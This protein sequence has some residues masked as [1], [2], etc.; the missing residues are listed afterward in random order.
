MHVSHADPHIAER[1]REL[2]DVG[3]VRANYKG[4]PAIICTAGM[5]GCSCASKGGG[6][7]DFSSHYNT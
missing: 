2:P 4:V 3:K 6:A 5:R 7:P 1:L